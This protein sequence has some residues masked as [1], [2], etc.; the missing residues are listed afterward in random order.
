MSLER[1]GVLPAGR[2]PDV[3][4]RDERRVLVAMVDGMEIDGTLHL[5]PGTR[6]LDL[7]N[8]ATEAFVAITEALVTKGGQ[9]QQVGFIAANKAHIVSLRDLGP[10]R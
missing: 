9:R 6:P 2:R 4:P 8:R 5:P 7:L 10:A 3:V 1:R